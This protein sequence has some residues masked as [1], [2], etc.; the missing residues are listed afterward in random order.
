VKDGFI[1]AP[2]GQAITKKDENLLGLRFSC[3]FGGSFF[4][5]HWLNQQIMDA[6]SNESSQWKNAKPGFTPSGIF[7]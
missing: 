2:V 4:H 3:P 7:S 6:F 5:G 1:S